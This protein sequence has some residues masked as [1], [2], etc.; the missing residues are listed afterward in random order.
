MTLLVDLIV[1]VLLIFVALGGGLR[2]DTF[3]AAAITAAFL[4]VGVFLGLYAKKQNKRE[5]L[6]GVVIATSLVLL[7]EVTCS[8][9]AGLI[10]R[11]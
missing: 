2:S 5:F 7:L 11:G 1:W 10:L 9:W 3:F 6:Q 8:S 4:G